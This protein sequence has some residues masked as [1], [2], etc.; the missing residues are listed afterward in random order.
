[1]KY[2]NFPVS[3]AEKVKSSV[4]VYQKTERAVIIQLLQ[5]IGCYYTDSF[6]RKNT[7]LIC[8]KPMGKKYKKAKEW[9]ISVST[10]DWLLACVKGG[11]WI[12]PASEEFSLEQ[13]HHNLSVVL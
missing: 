11:K 5:M 9:N 7:H 1:M 8:A 12:S 13:D 10:I 6:G 3:E 2:Y 4:S